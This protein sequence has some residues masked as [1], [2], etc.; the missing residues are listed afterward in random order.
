MNIKIISSIPKL[1]K[2]HISSCCA[3]TKKGKRCKNR[4][5]HYTTSGFCLYHKNRNGIHYDTGN[6]CSICL[7]KIKN[8]IKMFN[9]PHEFCTDC[10]YEWMYFNNS[11]PCCRRIIDFSQI[12]KAKLY[13]LV[14][15]KIIIVY[16]YTY[17]S[18]VLT[19]YEYSLIISNYSDELRFEINKEYLISEWEFIKN[20]NTNKKIFNKMPYYF[21]EVVVKY[22]NNIDNNI[23]FTIG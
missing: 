3:L 14:N 11:C 17:D 1:L 22:N 6:D 2:M 20:N 12:N 8:P 16:K 13:G 23:I 21:S 9:C 4:R 5:E 18:S 7:N 15:K 19:D 10:I